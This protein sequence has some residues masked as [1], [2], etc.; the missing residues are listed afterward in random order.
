M[1]E[2]SVSILFATF[3]R[4]T[5]LRNTL[6][7]MVQLEPAR[8]NFEIIVVDNACEKNIADLVNS[9]Q[10]QLP[11]IYLHEKQSGKHS[12]LLT[13]LEKAQGD[14]LVFIDDD[15][16]VKPNWLNETVNGMARF[17][18]YDLFGGK[19]LPYLA[20]DIKD[21]NGILQMD[22]MFIKSAFGIANWSWPEGPM[23]IGYIWGGNMAVRRR[24]FESGVSFNRHIGPNGKDYIMG[25]ETEFLV[26]AEEKGFKGVYLPESVVYHQIRAEQLSINWLKERALRTGKGKAMLAENKLPCFFGAPRYLWKRFLFACLKIIA[27][28]LYSKNQRINNVIQFYL[29]KGQIQQYKKVNYE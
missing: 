28:P 24:V 26:R 23:N 22:S 8:F 1:N 21:P 27:A 25:G 5:I 16:M 2:I 11:I 17:P 12:A 29:I 4:E 13:G 9:Y 10:Q 3:K 14:I 19:I 18:E 15:I 6:N 7:A 20:E